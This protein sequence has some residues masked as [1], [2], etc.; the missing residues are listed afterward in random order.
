MN[1]RLMFR[2]SNDFQMGPQ[3]NGKLKVVII[4]YL[5][6]KLIHLHVFPIYFHTISLT[7]PYVNRYC[8]IGRPVTLP[9]RLETQS[10]SPLKRLSWSRIPRRLAN[11]ELISRLFVLRSSTDRLIYSTDA[12]KLRYNVSMAT[13][14]LTISSFDQEDEGLYRCSFN[15][16]DISYFNLSAYGW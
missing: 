6:L 10:R 5:Q 11:W 1:F 2:V 3:Q 14:S 16:Q 7:D 13:G 15:H 8:F 9:C 12:L 4:C